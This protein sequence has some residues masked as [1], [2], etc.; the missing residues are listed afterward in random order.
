MSWGLGGW[1][2]GWVGGWFD[3]PFGGGDVHVTLFLD[4]SGQPGFDKRTPAQHCT[5]GK[6][7]GVEGLERWVGGWVSTLCSSWSV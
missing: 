4:L 2:G 1:V 3:V 5:G 7:S 6:V